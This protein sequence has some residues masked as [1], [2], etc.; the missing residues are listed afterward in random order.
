MNEEVQPNETGSH[1]AKSIAS[2]RRERTES[3]WEPAWPPPLLGSRVCRRWDLDL[4]CSRHLVWKC[5][6]PGRLLCDADDVCFRAPHAEVCRGHPSFPPG[7]WRGHSGCPGHQSLGGCPRWYVHSGRLLPHGRDQLPLGHAVSERGR[8]CPGPFYTRDV[9]RRSAPARAAQLVRSERECESEP[10]RGSDRISE[11][12]RSSRHRLYAPLSLTVPRA[13]PVH[14]CASETD[15]PCSSGRLC[16]LISRLLGPGEYFTVIAGHEDAP[17]EG[18]WHC[19]VAGCVNDRF[20]QS[21]ADHVRDTL[22]P[23]AGGGGPGT[24]CA[25]HLAAW[26]ALGQYRLADRGGHQRQCATD[27]CR[28]H[29]HYWLLSCLP[30]AFT[31]GVLPAVYPA[32]QYAAGNAAFLYSPCH[33]YSHLRAHRGAG[34]YNGSG[35]P[36]CLRAVGSLYAHMRGPGYCA[37]PR[38]QGGAYRTRFLSVCDP[39][40]SQE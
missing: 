21:A 2:N 23:S 20:D 15:S 24:L 34:Q 4:L 10:G 26:W 29:G 1:A 6:E 40:S 3:C 35:R 12:Y 16:W 31:H 36:I 32:T 22:A 8:A 9:H 17:Q 25:G 33:C 19:L 5:R 27:L 30:C 38:T 11:R 39:G 28:E 7:R 18:R 13:V 37:T 14:V